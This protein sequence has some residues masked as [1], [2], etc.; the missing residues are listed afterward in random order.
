MSGDAAKPAPPGSVARRALELVWPQPGSAVRFIVLLIMLAALATAFAGLALALIEVRRVRLSGVG[1]VGLALAALGAPLLV[2]VGLG[3]GER[4]EGARRLLRWTMPLLAV[5]LAWGADEAVGPNASK[6]ARK[7][8]GHGIAAGLAT[9]W[10]WVM[11][12]RPDVRALFAPKRL[13]AVLDDGVLTFF[14]YYALFIVASAGAGL[15][16][17]AW[18][19]R[20]SGLSPR[21][22]EAAHLIG[23]MLSGLLATIGVAAA[24]ALWRG[25]EADVDLVTPEAWT[26]IVSQRER[27]AADIL[28]DLEKD[29]VPPPGR[30]WTVEVVRAVLRT[31]DPDY[32]AEPR[33]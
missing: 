9:T 2:S 3:I 12:G 15:A 18:P 17:A 21:A 26:R 23:S 16:I 30:R 5:L 31:D 25:P 29:G 24:R 7:L 27:P 10:A 1:A 32:D 6:Q 11:L 22:A 33:V 19:S 8:V 4:S 14:G 28:A 13:R 20:W